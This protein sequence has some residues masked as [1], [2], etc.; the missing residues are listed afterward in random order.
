[1]RFVAMICMATF[2]LASAA[3][4]GDDCDTCRKA[5]EVKYLVCLNKAKKEAQ[6]K[7]CDSSRDTQKNICQM[8]KCSK[9]F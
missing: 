6:K 2:M 3:R 8:S 4:A 9:F 1:M 5:V 7:E